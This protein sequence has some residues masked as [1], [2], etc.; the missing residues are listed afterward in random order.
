MS[1]TTHTLLQAAADLLR[2]HCYP[3][4]AHQVIKCKRGIPNVPIYVFHSTT[5]LATSD[6][7]AFLCRECKA[8][9]MCIKKNPAHK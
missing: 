6:P 3:S 9:G 8:D 5:A 4:V 1:E 7:C 2:D